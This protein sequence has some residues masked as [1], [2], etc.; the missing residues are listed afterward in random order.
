MDGRAREPAEL[1]LISTTGA[2][3]AGRERVFT[4]DRL[5]DRAN[6]DHYVIT[7]RTVDSH[8]KNLR[9]KP[10]AAQPGEKPIRSI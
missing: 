1:T 10:E 6:T 2:L 9:R 8:I 4:R 5:P 7:D 3:V